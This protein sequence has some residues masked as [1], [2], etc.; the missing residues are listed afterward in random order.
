MLQGSERWLCR[1]RPGAP[2]QEPQLQAQAE[3]RAAL[4]FAERELAFPNF[5]LASQVR[6]GIDTSCIV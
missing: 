3:A 2:A 6:S 1:R 4:P 5:D